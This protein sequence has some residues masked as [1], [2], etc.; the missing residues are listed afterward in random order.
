MERVK[1]DINFFF[2]ARFLEIKITNFTF[3]LTIVGV[4]N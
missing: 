1:G 2:L 3:L 4:N